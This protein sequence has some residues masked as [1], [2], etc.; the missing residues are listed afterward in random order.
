MAAA[1]PALGA[2]PTRYAGALYAAAATDGATAA[3]LAAELEKAGADTD[4]PTTVLAVGHN[5]GWEEAASALAGAPV[6]LETATA[7]LF[8]GAAKA[9]ASW[10]DAL[11]A[12][13][14][15]GA[16]TL[17]GVVAGGA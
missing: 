10:P 14:E 15:D 11:T 2:A 9:A 5:R 17:V 8:E 3:A 6:R 1:V 7:A 16:W 12:P 4:A 13:A